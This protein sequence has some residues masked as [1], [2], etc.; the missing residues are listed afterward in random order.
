[1]GKL[2]LEFH[3]QLVEFSQTFTA[4]LDDHQ[5][6]SLFTSCLAIHLSNIHRGVSRSRRP[7][8]VE[9]SSKI[10]YAADAYPQTEEIRKVRQQEQLRGFF[11]ALRTIPEFS[12]ITGIAFT[13]EKIVRADGLVDTTSQD[14][15][16]LLTGDALAQYI[17]NV[18]IPDTIFENITY[19]NWYYLL[20]A[21]LSEEVALQELEKHDPQ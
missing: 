13:K 5:R 1:M 15:E 16:V 11:A 17:E 18:E 9:G 12:T 6:A 21:Y 2:S 8:T 19:T 3:R 14:D 7:E 10:V 4:N 20:L